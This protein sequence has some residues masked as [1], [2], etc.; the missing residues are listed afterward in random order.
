VSITFSAFLFAITKSWILFTASLVS[1]VLIDLD[2][3]LDFLWEY[4]MRFVVQKFFDAHYNRKILFCMIIFHSWELLIPLNIY[5]FLV[6]GNSWVIGIT[7]GLTQH[8]ILDQTFNKKINKC[9]YFFFWRLKNDF[10]FK[11]MLN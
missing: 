6:G 1:G 4:R 9:I 2:H 8:I 5:A 7:I 10:S 11:K 3:V